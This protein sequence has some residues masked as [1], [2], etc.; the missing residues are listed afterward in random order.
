MIKPQ[1]YMYAGFFYDYFYLS[2]VDIYKRSFASLRFT[3]CLM[4]RWSYQYHA[5]SAE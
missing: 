5:L 1:P 4:L 3:F 2:Q